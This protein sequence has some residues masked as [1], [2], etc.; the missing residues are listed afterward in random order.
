M[1]E[2]LNRFFTPFNFSIFFSVLVLDVVVVVVAN[3]SRE[4]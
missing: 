3:S 4:E 1:K 2:E